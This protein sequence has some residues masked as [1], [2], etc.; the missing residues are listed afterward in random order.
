MNV[1]K[2]ISSFLKVGC[3]FGTLYIA[4]H[5]VHKYFANEDSS[6]VNTKRFSQGT[7]FPAISLC[8]RS[9]HEDG[10]LYNHNYTKAKL[11]IGSKDYM[12]V[13][14]GRPL[15]TNLTRIANAEFSEA[16]IKL[17]TYLKKFKVRDTNENQFQWKFNESVN[18]VQDV[19]PELFRRRRS[20]LEESIPKPRSLRLK[21]RDP[22]LI[23]YEYMTDLIPRV[24]IDS[25][26]FYFNISRM[27]DI[28]NGELYIYANQ[29]NQLIRNLR[30]VYQIRSFSGISKATSTNMIV[31]DLNSISVIKAREDA[32]EPCDANLED[33]DA[34]WMRHVVE[35][36]GCVPSYWKAFYQGPEHGQCTTIEQLKNMSFYLPSKNEFGRM[37][38]LGK[39]L[40]PCT[41]M[42]V[43][44][45][46]NSDQYYK[47]D[48]FKLKIRF[49]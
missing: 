2:V 4:I 7:E 30:Y 23:C 18:N 24:T 39:Y 8:F 9:R 10:G 15:V 3:G 36:V 38:I 46:S 44:S 45:S 22:A 42:R 1:T 5:L 14:L 27:Q 37:A 28:K 35:T 40:Q 20:D 33:D 41:R 48:M 12:N 34:E 31:L 19:V 49:R 6:Y 21:Y 32:N 43:Q 17:Q 29:P 47:E 11:G 16:I 13:L 25:V 26:D